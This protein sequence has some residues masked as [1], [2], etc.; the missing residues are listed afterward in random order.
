MFKNMVW[1]CKCPLSYAPCSYVCGTL[2]TPD[3]GIYDSF[4]KFS[5][6]DVVSVSPMF[7]VSLLVGCLWFAFHL[8]NCTWMYDKPWLLSQDQEQEPELMKSTG[9]VVKSLNPKLNAE[10]LRGRAVCWGIPSIFRVILAGWSSSPSK[11]KSVGLLLFSHQVMSY[12][13]WPHE[14]QQTRLPCPSQSPRDA[15]TH[16]HWVSDAIQPSHPLSPPSP[17]ALSLP[18]FFMTL[19]I[20]NTLT[21]LYC[22]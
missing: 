12:S 19:V 7:P 3:E 4:S 1:G 20:V 21:T 17:P 5:S 9:H 18:L 10:W 8:R 2:P 16:V 11:D 6:P 13:L 14:L 22:E 15:Q